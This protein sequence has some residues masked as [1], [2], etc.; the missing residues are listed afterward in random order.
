MDYNYWVPL[1]KDSILAIAAVIASVI[2]ILGL[3][4][5]KRQLYGQSEYE[6]AKRLLKSL[7]LFREAINNVRHP[8][9][10]YSAIP[11]LPQDKLE[12][13]SREEK[14]W[15]AQA[16]AYEKRW[17]PVGKARADLD[18]NV[19]ESEVFWDNEIKHSMAKLS[20][21][22]AELLVAIEEHIERTNPRKPDKTYW[23]DNLRNNSAIMYGRNDRS[24]DPF[25]DRML[26]AIEEIEAILKPYIRKGKKSKKTLLL[27]PGT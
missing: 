26:T 17:T 5:W 21:L 3:N 14:E 25:L 13:L 2:A 7:Y 20:L 24:K 16:Q 23:G 9:M 19:L 27:I 1:I 8:F 4:T 11:D 22:Q 18:A 6:L 10:Q 15:Y 12:Q